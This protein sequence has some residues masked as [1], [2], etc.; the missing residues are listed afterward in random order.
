VISKEAGWQFRKQRK[1]VR[2]MYG[3]L[4]LGGESM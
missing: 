1:D 4:G 3:I 2:I